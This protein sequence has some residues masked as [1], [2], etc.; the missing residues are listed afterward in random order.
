MANTSTWRRR[1][2]AVLGALGVGA[3]AVIVGLAGPAEA[4]TPKATAK[5]DDGKTVLKVELTRYNPQKA[6]T[7]S[8]TDEGKSLLETDFQTDFK[9]VWEVAGDVDHNFVVKV[10]A[11]D[12]PDG[13]KGF[14]FT[15]KL[16]VKA[17]VT[18]PTTTTTKPSESTPETTTSESA[19]A[20]TTSEEEAPLANTGASIGLPLG[21]GAL[22]LVGGGVLLVVMRRRGRA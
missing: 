4:H 12:D 19:P 21:I 10:V 8:V 9:K 3:V 20:T 7:L 16:P 5:C 22:L 13:K 2:G 1:T 6:N 15:E 14:S 18:K 17:C 11:W